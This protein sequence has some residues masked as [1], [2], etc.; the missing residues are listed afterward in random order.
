MNAGFLVVDKPSGIS[1]NAVVSRVRKATG[2]RKAGH[3]GTLDPLATG[4][5]VVAVGPVT[6]LIRFIQDQD[7]EYEATAV[8]GVAT[9]TLDADGAVMSRE[10]MEI[11]ESDVES[12]ARRFVGT[13][14]QVP[15][16]VSALKHD[17]RRLYELARSGD[18]VERKS[19][20]VSIHELEIVSVGPG[21]YPEVEFRVVCGK[22]TYV[23]SLADDMAAALGGH[24]HLSALRRTRIGGL[25]VKDH[26]IAVAD[27]DRWREA[28]LSPSDALSSLPSVIVGAE[29]CD[30]VRNGMPFVGGELI[31]APEG[32]PVRVLDG[33]GDLLAI[34]RRDGE[35]ARPEVVIPA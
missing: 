26:G 2:V 12:V 25:T 16:M 29:T 35:S 1:S 17:G 28:L 20:P 18:V 34:Y 5:L 31:E 3:A 32:Q 15:P 10:P 4:V 22:G 6:R 7:K 21:P 8:F 11:S 14:Q 19:R 27:L 30:G 9:D 23:R 13:I 33:E 24:A